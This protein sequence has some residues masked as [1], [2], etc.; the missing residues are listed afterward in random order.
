[1]TQPLHLGSSGGGR[2]DEAGGAGGG[3]IKL[4]VN[5]LQVDG[6]IL[7]NG[8]DGTD[9]GTT[10]AGGGGSGGSI[11][12]VAGTLAGSTSGVIAADGG[13]GGSATYNGGGGGGGRV[14]VQYTT[15]TFAGTVRAQGG[16]ASATAETGGAG[17]LWLKDGT[18]S[19][20]LI[21]ANGRSSMLGWKGVWSDSSWSNALRTITLRQCGGITHPAN[22]TNDKGY[23]V[24]V[25]V[26]SLTIESN[27]FIYASGK[28]YAG[29]VLS[30]GY[31]TNGV[32]TPGGGDVFGATGAGG[33][34]GGLGGNSSRDAAGGVSYGSMTQPTH[35]GS[36]GGGSG[37]ANYNGV[38]GGG[39]IK[40]NV[41]EL[42]VDGS[43]LA[44]GADAVSGTPNQAP[45][46]GSGGSIWII[47]RRLAGTGCM[48]ANGGYGHSGGT[49]YNGGGGG[50]GRIAVYAITAPFYT[51]GGF[52]GTYTVSGGAGG[53]GGSTPGYAGA[54]GTV[55]LNFKPRGTVL[56]TW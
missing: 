8:A 21:I 49:I 39:A 1:V 23:R 4:V 47:T 34:H 55:Y 13:V 46:G 27:G 53:N 40:L 14:A 50:G 17:T 56:C 11:W 38:A 12:I 7:A 44:N 22:G 51:A 45:G 30:A 48:N 43:I 9:N 31:G 35:L 16:D 24:D 15:K 33:G 2:G 52:V 6:S 25:T 37:N 54:V 28:G 36:G 29:G 3:A 42:Q 32:G 20:D 19:P 26:P 41:G 10:R 18:N 5:L